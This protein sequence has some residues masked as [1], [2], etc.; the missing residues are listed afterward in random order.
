MEPRH[1]DHLLPIGT[2]VGLTGPAAL[3]RNGSDL[4]ALEDL[5]FED[6]FQGARIGMALVD[7][8]GTTI[9]TNPAMQQMLGYTGEELLGMA[10][11]Q[12][13]RPDDQGADEHLFE[14]VLAGK[15]DMYQVE[16]R[17][18]RK[19]GSV[20]W[21]HLTV[22]L[23]G[24]EGSSLGIG[25]IEDITAR[26]RAEAVAAGQR[27]V[28]EL[29]ESCAPLSTTLKR[30]AELVE[31]L[32]PETLASILLAEGASCLRHAVAPS[33]PAAFTDAVDR[34]AI[35]PAAGSC[36]TAAHRKEIVVVADIQNDPLWADYRE[37]ALTHGLRSCSSAP[38]LGKAGEVLG[39]FG[40]YTRECRSPRIEELE[41]VQM[42]GQLAVIAIERHRAKETLTQAH[43]SYRTLIEQLPLVTYTVNLEPETRPTT[44][45]SPQAQELLGYSQAEWLDDSS[46]LVRHLHPDDRE[47][48]LAAW[49][50]TCELGVPFCLEYR[51]LAKD[52]Q[53][54]WV[55]DQGLVLAPGEGTP[56]MFQ[57][58]MFDVT[59]RKETEQAL[60]ASEAQ[61][62][63]AQK[64]EAVGLLAGGIAHDFNN[65]L[66][67]IMGAAEL[68]SAGFKEDDPKKK[69]ADE[70]VRSA[71][72]GAA[73]T[74]QLLA[75]SRRQVLAPRVLDLNAI[76]AE[77]CDL[78]HRLLGDQT[79]LETRLEPNLG[80]VMADPSQ[81]EQV[82]LNLAVNA[83]DA[84]PD[85]GQITIQ[86]NNLALSEPLITPQVTVPPG[87]YARLSVRDTGTGMGAEQLGRA[88]EPFYTTK[89][90]G[91]GTGLGLSTVYGI[92]KQS[93][94]YIW[95]DSSLGTG[96]EIT[97]CLSTVEQPL[98]P[99]LT[100]PRVDEVPNGTETILLVEDDLTVR[101]IISEA[102]Q[103]LGYRV[104][105]LG[106]PAEA[107]RLADKRG[108]EIDLLVT[109]ITMPGMNGRELA[110]ELRSKTDSRLAVLYM[111][112]Q[113]PEAALAPM[114][115][116]PDH[117][118]LQKPFPLDE[119]GLS[120]RAVLD[121]RAS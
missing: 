24:H 25:M 49:A 16:K 66:A 68:L 77:S 22:S 90:P 2:R 101:G 41:L 21:G 105:S 23:L 31:E 26:K 94:G 93:G 63:K 48:A 89:A 47:H 96:T 10:V 54:V 19:D 115:L 84:M 43:I 71:Q 7:M 80:H 92:A 107:V 74:R 46:F 56:R 85:G 118:F 15:L 36:G 99:L 59:N 119:L 110:G 86:T 52:G 40:L 44:Y 82:L 73:L 12:F 114:F 37:L 116:E 17:Y 27:R 83:R 30:L 113:A 69:C 108:E 70:V 75:F 29:I 42:A 95:V 62:H 50:E 87:T 120:V 3:A 76:V 106:D 79:R 11:P 34:V 28:L 5:R 13:T 72:R 100:K 18:M 39:T 33:L 20:L 60:Q 104:L 4:E 45:V 64:F 53:C 112:G 1:S 98:E 9:V 111:S 32:A 38:I 117:H 91:Q 35:G 88:F 8:A 102:L 61:L 109:D 97:L 121:A 67:A 51:L 103:R 14:Q 58:F 65:I 81:L 78:L 57:G 55:L 6:A